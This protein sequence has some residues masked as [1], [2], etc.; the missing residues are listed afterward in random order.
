MSY[1]QQ[2]TPHP[3]T[4]NA[5]DELASAEG[6]CQAPK[7]HMEAPNLSP[8]EEWEPMAHAGLKN[9]VPPAGGP[10]VKQRGL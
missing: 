10:N 7:H 2:G 1:A 8:S 3:L 4:L 5:G 6:F 9:W